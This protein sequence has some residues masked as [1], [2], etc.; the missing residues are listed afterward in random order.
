MIRVIDRRTI[1][2]SHGNM[3]FRIWKFR[4]CVNLK[5]SRFVCFYRM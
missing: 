4:V 1:T 2:N 5:I 3:N